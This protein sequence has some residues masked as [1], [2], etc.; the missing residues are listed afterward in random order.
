[1]IRTIHKVDSVAAVVNVRRNED[2]IKAVV[3]AAGGLSG[4]PDHTRR[5]VIV[6]REKA[7][8]YAIGSAQPGDIVL[9]VGKGHETYEIGRKGIKAFD[10]KKI[11]REALKERRNGHTTED[12]NADRNGI[13]D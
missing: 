3:E 5:R 4:M 8:R 9:L 2:E 11:V 13:S 6:D 12:G 10:E 7:I 1:M